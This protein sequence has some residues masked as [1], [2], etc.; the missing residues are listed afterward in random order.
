MAA[1]AVPDFEQIMYNVSSIFPSIYAALGA[2]VMLMAVFMAFSG[3][4]DLAQT[5]EKN[6]KFFG[7]NQA[8]MVSG[9][10]KLVLAG[11][12]ANFAYSGELVALVSEGFF[13]GDGSFELVSIDSY[14][15]EAPLNQLQRSIQIVL[16]SLTQT[17]GIIA[18][19]KG[20]RVWYR[21]SD[22]SG[23]ESTVTGLSYIIAGVL[24]VQVML[25]IKVVENTLG[26]NLLGFFGMG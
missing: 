20:I 22:R 2:L 4:V 8:S 6:K 18:I 10:V 3:V 24:C 23:R 12:M 19:I 9:I 14:S 7:T 13:G 25:V 21:A 11:L 5:G 1:N 15:P 16:I 26:Y 17:V